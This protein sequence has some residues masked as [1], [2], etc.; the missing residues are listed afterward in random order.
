M[1]NPVSNCCRFAL[2]SRIYHRQELDTVLKNGARSSS[3]AVVSTTSTV[4]RDNK[5]RPEGSPAKTKQ[6]LDDDRLLPG[7]PR[8]PASPMNDEDGQDASIIA[9]PSK[10]ASL[11]IHSNMNST[12]NNHG[13]TTIPRN[14]ATPITYRVTR[15]V[16]TSP[17]Y[18]GSTGI[19]AT[20]VKEK[21][22]ADSEPFPAAG[23]DEP[24]PFETLR[25]AS[26][27]LRRLLLSLSTNLSAAE[28]FSNS[29]ASAGAR[30][31]G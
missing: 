30:V 19:A 5:Y 23:F 1:S 28:A 10:I 11:P 31:G 24:S 12:L 20:P 27:Q 26:M 9:K 14:T 15:N 13:P 4:Q 8:V 22:D 17:N 2:V 3:S 6:H 7:I 21:R 25:D 29:F 16:D 18:V